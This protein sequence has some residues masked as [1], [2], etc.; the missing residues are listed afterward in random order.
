MKIPNKDLSSEK[1]KNMTMNSKQLLS[2]AMA[3]FMFLLVGC[4]GYSTDRPFRKNVCTVAVKPFGSKEFRRRIEMDL[5]EAVK[6]R[7][8]Q[9]TPY[10]LAD[11]SVADTVLTGEVLQV[12]QATMGRDF[13]CNLPRETQM[14]LI[15]K[16]QWK[17]LR[18][19]EVLVQKD[20]W[21]QT[22]DW[23]APV[24]ENQEIAIQGAVD[25]MAETIVE[26]MERDW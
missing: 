3:T 1:V 24:G 2:L 13:K 23:S 11:A 16:F 10:K 15:V 8:L 9:D 18:S 20:R 5:T 19:G 17:D 22:Y 21:L 4:S 7:I 12:R 26:Q 14:T 6:K 25:R